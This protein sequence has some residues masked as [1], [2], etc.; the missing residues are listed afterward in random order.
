MAVLG[1]RTA[2]GPQATADR[3]DFELA[4]DKQLEAL[5]LEK[6]RTKQITKGDASVAAAVFGT[7]V[8]STDGMGLDLSDPT[9]QVV[10][11]AVLA[12]AV[13]AYKRYR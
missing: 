10:G 5:K 13:V 2:W 6:E 11:L 7:S 8:P 1:I 3:R 4:K 12:A 9:T